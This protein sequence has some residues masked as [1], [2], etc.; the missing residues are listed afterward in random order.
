MLF[1][2]AACKSAMKFRNYF[3]VSINNPDS[4]VHEANIGPT[5]VLSAPD[6]PHVGPMN[7]AIRDMTLNPNQ[8]NVKLEC[9]LHV[10]TTCV[11]SEITVVTLGCD[12]RDCA[13]DTRHLAQ[14]LVS[15]MVNHH[16]WFVGC[17]ATSPKKRKLEKY[18]YMKDVSFFPFPVKA[19]KQH[20]WERWVWRENFEVTRHRRICSLHW[21]DDGPCVNKSHPSIFSHNAK[22]KD[23]QGRHSNMQHATKR[24]QASHVG[25]VL[26]QH[27][28]SDHPMILGAFFP[29]VRSTS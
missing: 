25:R 19:E 13:W 23:M 3:Q 10:F 2:F 12:P 4:K 11:K 1:Q 5:W 7:L 8:R 26:L 17:T 14:N 28:G 24:Q 18:S 6:G 29:T 27:H 16:C 9:E 20:L 22:W 21:A 15:D